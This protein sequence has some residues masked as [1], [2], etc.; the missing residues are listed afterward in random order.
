MTGLLWAVGAVAGMLLQILPLKNWL[1]R[2]GSCRPQAADE[3]RASVI[4]CFR[5]ITEGRPHPLHFVQ[6]LPCR[7]R[8]LLEGGIPHAIQY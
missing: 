2:G 6:H 4:T 5:T 1:P 7:G 3:G 8:L